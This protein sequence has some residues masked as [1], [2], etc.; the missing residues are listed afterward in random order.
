MNEN[1]EKAQ[2]ENSSMSSE[3]SSSHDWRTKR[4]LQAWELKEKGWSQRQIAA[5]LDV[6][7]GAVSQWFK[8]AKSHGVNA[9]MPKSGRRNRQALSLNQLQR[10]A[11]CIEFGAS[12]FGFD[13]NSWTRDRFCWLIENKFNIKIEEED[14]AD[15]DE[16]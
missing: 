7:E 8:R 4:R 11:D 3:P 14:I 9:L 5:E 10:L 13:D 15:F 12:A 6:S 2:S 16:D 1:I